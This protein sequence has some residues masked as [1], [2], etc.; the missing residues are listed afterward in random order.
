MNNIIE[1]LRCALQLSA[2]K[3][4][5]ILRGLVEDAIRKEESSGMIRGGNGSHWEGC[6]NVH[7][8]CKIAKLE[9]TVAKL[10]SENEFLQKL[11]FGCVS[12]QPVR[13]KGNI[14]P[15][16]EA[17]NGCSRENSAPDDIFASLLISVTEGAKFFSGNGGE[18]E[19]NSDP[20]HDMDIML[21][22]D[23]GTESRGYY[24]DMSS[25]YWKYVDIGEE[26]RCYPIAWRELK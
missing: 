24:S 13:W 22:F 6:E 19:L 14:F 17:E 12:S 25:D 18:W 8:D 1:N 20:D 10:K 21:L 5:G 7:W 3:E 16:P 26:R 4:N 2:V 9:R 23:D 11:S 15:K